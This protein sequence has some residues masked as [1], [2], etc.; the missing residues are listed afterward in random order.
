MEMSLTEASN[1]L[2]SNLG[3]IRKSLTNKV[4][5]ELHAKCA[6]DHFK[7]DLEGIRSVLNDE[8]DKT[9]YLAAEA[10]Y[11][12]QHPGVRT[13]ES[14]GLIAMA[15]SMCA[16]SFIKMGRFAEAE[17]LLRQEQLLDSTKV[18]KDKETKALNISALRVA[19]L[20][21]GK[22]GEAELL[23]QSN[24]A[25]EVPVKQIARSE[26]EEVGTEMKKIYEQAK[27]NMAAD[28]RTTLTSVDKNLLTGTE[29]LA[30]LEKKMRNTP[31]GV[32]LEQLKTEHAATL[33][34]RNID[35]VVKLELQGMEDLFNGKYADAEAKLR[36]AN[37][38]VDKCE[39]FRKVYAPIAQA[40]SSLYGYTL[41]ALTKYSDA[42]KRFREEIKRDRT[43]RN[44]RD[45]EFRQFNQL[46]LKYALLRQGKYA[47]VAQA[48]NAQIGTGTAP[49]PRAVLFR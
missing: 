28:I 21:Q 33:N 14:N 6:N 15:T 48:T 1:C 44:T 27:L 39:D 11:V 31:E 8:K 10:D 35:Q 3:Q 30:E 17:Q 42:E 47:D 2:D 40:A 12:R 7:R 18:N 32:L 46:A 9:G 16:V 38:V 41:M 20:Q 26:A 37:N 36:A 4:L 49:A 5:D 22:Y 34:R 29:K 19:L 23:G 43:G 25:T 24:S 13:T 45:S